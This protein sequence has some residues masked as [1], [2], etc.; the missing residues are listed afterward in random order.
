VSAA[1]TSPVVAGV[2]DGGSEGVF[3]GKNRSLSW[4]IST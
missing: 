2:S 1:A 3:G 4:L